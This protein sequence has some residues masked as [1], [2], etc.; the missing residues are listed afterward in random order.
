MTYIQRPRFRALCVLSMWLCYFFP[1]CGIAQPTILTVGESGACLYVQDD[2]ESEKVETL[3]AGQEVT[4]IL[5]TTGRG[6]WY[7]VRTKS[8]RT[9]WLRA[10]DVKP[11]GRDNP[12]VKT[13]DPVIRFGPGSTWRASSNRGMVLSGT[14]TG[15]INQ[16]TGTASGNWTVRDSA[17][18]IALSGTWSAAKSAQELRGSWRAR[19]AARAG[20]HSGTWSCAMQLPSNA[21]LADLFEW[22]VHQTLGGAW[23]SAGHSGNWSI[24]AVR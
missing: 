10:S 21:P 7:L 12:P 6:T 23:Q 3:R 22:A 1:V 20:E 2:T 18:R 17:N 16:S 8:G 11:I 5:Q 19:V 15:T 24:R 9:G 14:W 13:D 4:P